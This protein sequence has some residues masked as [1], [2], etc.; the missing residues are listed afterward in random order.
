MNELQLIP[1]N[2]IELIQHC[3]WIAFTEGRKRAEV[4]KGI[5]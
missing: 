3:A 5:V 2:R 1:R 4:M